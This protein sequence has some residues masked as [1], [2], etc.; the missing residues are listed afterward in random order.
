M[1]NNLKEVDLKDIIKIDRISKYVLYKEECKY[2]PYIIH[3][4]GDNDS[5]Y[6][7]TYCESL[8]SAIKVFENKVK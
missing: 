6:C 3:N 7:G 4:I 2:H 8:S 5:L 1:A